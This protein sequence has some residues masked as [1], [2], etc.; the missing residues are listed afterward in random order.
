MKTAINV[1]YVLKHSNSGFEALQNSIR[2]GGDVDSLASVCTGIA[3]GKYGL[4]SL[5]EFLLEQTEGFSRI[6]MLGGR[7]YEKFFNY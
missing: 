7:L 6:E 3:G 2:M 5:P 4:D 1:V